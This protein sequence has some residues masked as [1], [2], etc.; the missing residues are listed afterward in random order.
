M[1]YLLLGLALLVLAIL[2]ARALV[3]ADPK[4]LA[5]T[6]RRVGGYTAL[7]VALLFA[8]T[9]RF[10]L[11][12]P[13]A[14][15]GAMLLG[16]NLPGGFN[17][18]PGGTRKTQGQ[19]SRVRTATVEME[20]DHDTGDLDGRV[21]AG[22]FAG[23]MLSSLEEGALAGLWAEC[24][25]SD[26]QAAQLLEAYLDRYFPDWRDRA[27]AEASAGGDSSRAHAA[28]ARMTEEE[29][30]GVLGLEPGASAADIR[31]AHRTLMKKL[32]P[33]HGGSDYLAARINEAR[34]LLLNK[35]G[36]AGR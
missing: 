3:D 26:P 7:G 27:G 28:G 23:R 36:Q 2:A 22:R 25:A 34:E 16:W 13:L 10:A 8:L 12:V 29:A 5:R 30:Y 19:Q 14:A 21:V 33:D 20:L 15:A 17:P 35:R 32:H 31:R 6:V 4:N 24:D 11:A 9:G 1:A 18:F